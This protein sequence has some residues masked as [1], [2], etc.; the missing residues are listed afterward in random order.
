MRPTD[1]PK[2][3]R[4]SSGP[5]KK[6]PGW[7]SQALN[8]ASLGRSHRSSYCLE[9]IH[10]LTGLMRHLLEIPENYQ[11]AIIPGSCSAAMETALWSLLGPRP[12]DIVTFDVFGNLWAYD[13]LHELK[14]QNTHILEAPI[15]HLPDLSK[16][17]PT[18][19]LVFTWNGTA[20]GVVI[21]HADWLHPHREGLVL[22]DA[23]SAVFAMSFP[24]K[25]MDAVAF[26]WQ[27]GLGGE[28]AHGM[29]VLSPKAIERLNT[30]TPSWPMPRIFRLTKEGKFSQNI[31]Q[32]YTINTP[33]MLCIE[34]CIDAL[35]WGMSVG[36]LP[37]LI[38]RSQYNLQVVEEW[39]AETP[40]IEFLAQD[41]RTRSSTSICLRFI[42][43]PDDWELPKA[44]AA[45]L[46][47]EGVA[48]DILGHTSSVP[49]LRLWGGPTI[50]SSD[51]KALL[52][53]ITWA[54]KEVT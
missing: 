1:K 2:D 14:L 46:E 47:K 35:S 34:D 42:E 40:W 10:H 30:H 45:L 23:I 29:L 4:F 44:I 21:P 25:K 53:W 6:R 43:A 13:I 33:S 15:G 19:D 12:V 48:F 37:A 18:H 36:G 50:E 24:W 54:H 11:I 22:C 16:V 8:I 41:P 52:P 38:A 51:M 9:R 49:H 26:S 28:A 31:F 7:S 32:G 20:A 27:K 17:H 3:P 39:V 5:A